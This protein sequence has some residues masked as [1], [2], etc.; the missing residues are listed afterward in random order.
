ML[1]NPR[2]GAHPHR[3]HPRDRVHA[4]VSFAAGANYR[5]ACSRASFPG[6]NPRTHIL[7]ALGSRL[8]SRKSHTRASV[9]LDTTPSSLH[10][11]LAPAPAQ[12]LIFCSRHVAQLQ[13]YLA[14]SRWGGLL[15]SEAAGAAAPSAVAPSAASAPAALRIR[16]LTAPGVRTVR[17]F[18]APL[19]GPARVGVLAKDLGGG[20]LP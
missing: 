16:I 20:F 13:A 18:L 5:G 17:F 8:A 19:A 3:Q 6:D 10:A 9:T 14:S 7:S 1:A 4:R 15:F 11:L 2:A 12:I